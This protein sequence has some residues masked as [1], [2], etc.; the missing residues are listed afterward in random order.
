MRGKL[1]LIDVVS[2]LRREHLI[3]SIIARILEVPC[4]CISDGKFALEMKPTSFTNV[5]SSYFFK[6]M[7]PLERLSANNQ[8]CTFGGYES[9]N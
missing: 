8:R 1:R 6:T 3:G 5:S 7:K 2:G 9:E 4:T